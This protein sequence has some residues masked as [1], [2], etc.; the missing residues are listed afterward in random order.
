MLVQLQFSSS[1]GLVE[2]ELLAT[3]QNVYNSLADTNSGIYEPTMIRMT[4][5]GC[6]KSKKDEKEKK[7]KQRRSEEQRGHIAREQLSVTKQER[8]WRASKHANKQKIREETIAIRSTRPVCLSSRDRVMKQ[9]VSLLIAQKWINM[10]GYAIDSVDSLLPLSILCSVVF[11]QRV[12]QVF[13][14]LFRQ[15]EI[16]HHL[17]P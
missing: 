12:G 5:F 9:T 2:L 4:A 10:I 16:N 14:C 11:I 3:T 1:E 17:S 6:P 15:Y 7:T 8:T 13:V